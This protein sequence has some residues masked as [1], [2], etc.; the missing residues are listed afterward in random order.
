[1]GQWKAVRMNMTKNPEAPIELFQLSNDIGEQNNLAE[2]H[3]KVV[4]KIDSIMSRAHE[5]SKIFSFKHEKE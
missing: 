5:Y 1:M 2:K 4:Q 3:P